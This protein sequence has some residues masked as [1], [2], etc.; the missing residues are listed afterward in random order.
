VKFRKGLTF[1]Y[2]TATLSKLNRIQGTQDGNEIIQSE[3]SLAEDSAD[4]ALR[5]VRTKLDK[6]LSVEYT[7][8]EL[9]ATSIDPSNLCMIFS[10]MTVINVL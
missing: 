10:G 8:N 1:C 3:Q 7:V 5:S 4:R 9:I 6:S 2:R